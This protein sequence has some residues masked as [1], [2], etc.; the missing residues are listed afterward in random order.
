MK[1]NKISKIKTVEI[2]KMIFL[3]IIGF[4][5]FFWKKINKARTASKMYK[6]ITKKGIVKRNSKKYK[7]V[8]EENIG[9]GNISK[10]KRKK[11]ERKMKTNKI[12]KIKSLLNI[13]LFPFSVRKWSTNRRI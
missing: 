1:I 7:E 3:V 5:N 6:I 11:P 13:N 12:L 9:G 2:K 10:P 4:F 8:L